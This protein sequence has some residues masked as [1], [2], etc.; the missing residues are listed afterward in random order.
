MG[1]AKGWE[2]QERLGR[3]SRQVQSQDTCPGRNAVPRQHMT[4]NESGFL[5]PL[6]DSKA[7][8]IHLYCKRH[9]EEPLK[10]RQKAKLYFTLYPHPLP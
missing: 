6:P 10:R 9:W 5:L 4:W 7:I 8:Q 2:P 1:W 3:T